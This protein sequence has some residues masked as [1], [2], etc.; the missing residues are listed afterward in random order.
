MLVLRETTGESTA[1]PEALWKDHF[2]PLILAQVLS[3]EFPIFKYFPEKDVAS[4]FPCLVGQSHT[5]IT[6][7]ADKVRSPIP[8]PAGLLK[9]A[10]LLSYA[11]EVGCLQLSYPR[12]PKVQIVRVWRL[13]SEPSI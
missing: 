8:S 11:L 12:F 1:Q 3:Q 5:M 6:N 2:S 9:P 7:S 10:A 4:G 13:L